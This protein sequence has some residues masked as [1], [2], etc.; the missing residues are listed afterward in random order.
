M[1][2]KKAAKVNDLRQLMKKDGTKSLVVGFKVKKRVNI[3][4]PVRLSLDGI[5]NLLKN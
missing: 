5:I 3:L 4:E 2:G 1:T